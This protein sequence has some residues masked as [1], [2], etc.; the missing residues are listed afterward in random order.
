MDR[1]AGFLS[2]TY[3]KSPMS[4]FD[5]AISE[6]ATVLSRLLALLPRLALCNRELLIVNSLLNYRHLTLC[7][8]VLIS[9]KQPFYDQKYSIGILNKEH[10]KI[11]A[12]WLDFVQHKSRFGTCLNKSNLQ[13]VCLFCSNVQLLWIIAWNVH[14][15]QVS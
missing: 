8:S 11:C 6:N 1:K 12:V 10:G 14:G 5:G 9:L 2:Q 7:W 13:N 3:W 4:M 15:K